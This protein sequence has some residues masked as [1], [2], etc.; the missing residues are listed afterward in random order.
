MC[1]VILLLVL[2]PRAVIVIWWLVEPAQWS[3]TFTTLLLPLLGFVLLPWT[4]LVY[5]LVAPHGVVGLDFLWLALA[6]VAD[7]SSHAGGG[8]YRRR[9]GATA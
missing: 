1:L 9:R 8:V 2:G 6:L 7:V 3:A 5:V 4:T